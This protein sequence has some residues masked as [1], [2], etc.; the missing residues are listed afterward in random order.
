MK[1]TSQIKYLTIAACMLVMAGA[2]AQSRTSSPY[3]FFGLGQQT[4]RGTIVNR[5]MGGLRI[6]ADSIHAN[7]Q[8][9]AS[10]GH[11]RLTNYALGVVHT[12]TWAENSE[13]KDAYD[14]TSLEY[15]S[16]GVPLGKRMGFNFGL[17]PFKSVGYR[18]GDLTD[19]EY[20]NF[21]GDG[22]VNRAY[23]GG[24]ILLNDHFSLGAELRYNFGRETNSSSVGLINQAFLGTNELNQTDF[25]GLSGNFGVHYKGI[26]NGKYEVQA[27]TIFSPESNITADN[28]RTLSTF[29]LSGTQEIS[30]TVRPA[31]ETK[32]KLRLPS[33]L[34]IGA[35]IGKQRHWMLGAEYNRQGTSSTGVRS[36]L[37]QEAQFTDA[38]SYRLGGFYIPNYNSFT[39]YWSR[40]VYRGGL[41]WEETGLRINGEDISEFGISFGLGLPIGRKSGFSNANIGFE[42]GERGTTSN[43]LIK[44]DFFSISVG[45]SL[46]DRWFQK[47]KYN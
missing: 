18:I 36:F 29:L 12:E 43:G 22:S 9:P 24:G 45:L 4:F 28:S 33:E 19:T 32:Q 20:T 2:I 26:L 34:T 41:R 3:S 31:I 37:P 38:A 10:Y 17:V 30:S 42:Y 1:S 46:N 14:A 47:R 15:V 16:I 35:S 11:L 21:T 13:Q 27:S 25:S 39:S 44:E 7:I 23:I 8:N 6:Y 5:S 40:V